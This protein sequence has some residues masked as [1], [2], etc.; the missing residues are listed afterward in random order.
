MHPVAAIAVL[1]GLKVSGDI[2]QLLLQNVRWEDL[3]NLAALKQ[4]ILQ[5]YHWL[6]HKQVHKPIRKPIFDHKQQ[7]TVLQHYQI[8]KGKTIKIHQPTTLPT[9]HHGKLWDIF[10]GVIYSLNPTTKY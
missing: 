9:V 5:K 6:T 7:I 1:I 8:L 4:S 3:L 2:A 10:Q